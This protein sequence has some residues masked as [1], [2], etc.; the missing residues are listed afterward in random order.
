MLRRV[1]KFVARCGMLKKED[2]VIA[3]ISGGADSVCLFFMLLELQKKI[4]FEFTVLHVNHCL[5]GADADAD[6]AYVRGICEVCN[7][8]FICVREDVA[9]Y[10]AKNKISEEEAGRIVRREAFERAM[11]EQN[12]TKIALAHHRNDTAE[13]FIMN[14]AR[15]TGLKGLGAIRPYNGPYIRP[16]LCLERGE[17]EA[18]LAERGITYRQD[19]T[20]MSD[21]YT[22]N[23]VRNYVIPC[24]E[25]E[26]NQ[27][28]VAHI[29]RAANDFQK[30][31][32]YMEGEARGAY[33]NIAVK[34]DG[35]IFMSGDAFAKIHE[36]LKP[37][38]VKI[39]MADVC[40]REKD[41]TEAH[42]R[43]VAALFT[44]SVGKRVSL[45]YQMTAYKTY[46][47][48]RLTRGEGNKKNNPDAVNTKD[49]GNGE[50][51]S[52]ELDFDERDTVS[53]DW[54]KW[55]VTCRLVC[56]EREDSSHTSDMSGESGISGADCGV[57]DMPERNDTVMRFDYD[58]I[59]GRPCIRSRRQG[60]FI[61]VGA[62]GGRKKIKDFFIDRKVP[63]RERDSV[64][65]LA[66]GS[67]I[68]WIVGMR[69]NGVYRAGTDAKR[70]LEVR[71]ADRHF[72][73]PVNQT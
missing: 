17:I 41:L 64:P 9:L 63:R 18:Y 12:A 24:I 8:P 14:L 52:V 3:G 15:G 42:I 6:E 72:K 45:P 59:S 67:H 33:K 19:T 70:I 38:V 37:M 51:P 57:T 5:R 22:R 62:D 49:S 40:G 10:A 44:N 4:G 32:T 48:V 36:V 55:S 43:Q 71:V 69:S 66:D 23:R 39:A 61:T 27:K 34:T 21:T 30:I 29:A 31:W 11:R 56:R 7:V 50:Y 73:R 47:G 25:K 1:E 2:K 46:D 60:D 65:L 53:F 28:A 20:N 54:G 68:M 35:E 26:V 13:T 58:R 16:L